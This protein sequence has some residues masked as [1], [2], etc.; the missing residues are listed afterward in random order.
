MSNEKTSSIISALG[1]IEV[2]ASG[3]QVCD[4]AINE[5]R[6]LV[7]ENES[8]RKDAERY[9]WLRNSDHWPAVFDS[10]YAPEPLRGAGLDL[11]IDAAKATNE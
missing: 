11:T 4:A 7:D 10:H 2:T 6:R 1:S 8:L 5:L 9:R 3:M